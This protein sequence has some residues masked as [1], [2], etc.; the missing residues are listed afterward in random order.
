MKKADS[1]GPEEG[2]V[3][4]LRPSAAI[5]SDLSSQVAGWRRTECEALR[6]SHS[7]QEAGFILEEKEIFPAAAH[8][9]LA[10]IYHPNHKLYLLAD[11]TP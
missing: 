6:L 4:D 8:C 1:V 10:G 5:T 2:A 11:I 3:K 9:F 7:L